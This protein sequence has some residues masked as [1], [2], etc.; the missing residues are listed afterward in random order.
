[1]SRSLIT[2]F[3]GILRPSKQTEIVYHDSAMRY[4]V[5]SHTV[6]L[7][8]HDLYAAYLYRPIS[9]FVLWGSARV[10]RIQS[11]ILNAYIL[12]IVVALIVLLV[13]A[14]R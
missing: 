7:H 14:L 4:F 6:S 12:Y 8:L 11:G 2:M 9:R 10:K 5:S 13:I 1:F 3:K